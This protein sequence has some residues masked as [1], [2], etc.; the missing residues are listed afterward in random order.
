MGVDDEPAQD[1]GQEWTKGR[2]HLKIPTRCA[3]LAGR[4]GVFTVI[5]IISLPDPI[6]P[7]RVISL[8]LLAPSC[9]S[10][11][12]AQLTDTREHLIMSNRR[13]SQLSSTVSRHRTFGQK[14]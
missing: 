9:S 7:I 11:L 2:G 8:I 4:T 6:A 10:L 3:V 12:R 13:L 14:R 5:N 1:K